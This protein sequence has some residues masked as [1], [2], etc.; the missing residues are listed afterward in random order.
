MARLVNFNLYAERTVSEK[1]DAGHRTWGTTGWEWGWAWGHGTHTG[2]RVKEPARKKCQRNIFS[3][4]PRF[5]VPFYFPFLAVIFF[6]FLDSSNASGKRIFI[7]QIEKNKCKRTQQQDPR[8]MREAPL[9]PLCTIY[10]LLCI[11]YVPRRLTPYCGPSKDFPLSFAIRCDCFS[12]S[13]T[14]R[15][16]MEYVYM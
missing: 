8:S 11:T 7:R 14:C 13:H 5:F 4:F 2:R 9:Y 1:A 16:G 3:N 6:L 15:S 10:I 12:R